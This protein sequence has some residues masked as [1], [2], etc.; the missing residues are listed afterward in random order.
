MKRRHS[1]DICGV[2]VTKAFHFLFIF[3]QIYL[4]LFAF[5]HPTS[6]LILVYLKSVNLS[7]WVEYLCKFVTFDRFGNE[8]VKDKFIYPDR[9]STNL[10]KTTLEIFSPLFQANELWCVI[11]LANLA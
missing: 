11:N 4:Q 10:Q 7:N 3:L 8:W 6:Y 1:I 9:L 2:T 5:F